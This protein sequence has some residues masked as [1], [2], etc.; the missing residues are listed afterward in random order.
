MD[1]LSVRGICGSHL[2]QTLGSL[3]FGFCLETSRLTPA[4]CA[5]HKEVGTSQQGGVAE[6]GML[7]IRWVCKQCSSQVPFPTEKEQKKAITE[8]GR[9]AQV[10]LCFGLFLPESK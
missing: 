1:Q 9:E 8:K 10:R 3:H 2:G 7:G 6:E 4:I 5:Q